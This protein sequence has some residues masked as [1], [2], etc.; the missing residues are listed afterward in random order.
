MYKDVSWAP[1]HMDKR[2]AVAAWSHLQHRKPTEE[3]IA[4][5]PKTMAILIAC[6]KGSGN[7][8]VLDFDTKHDE[9][10]TIVQRW[11]KS[12]SFSPRQ[13][14][15]PIIR[16]MSGGYHI[17]YRLPYTPEGN[18]K[19]TRNPNGDAVIETRGQGGYVIAPPHPSYRVVYNSLDN[20][21]TITKE[22]HEEMFRVAVSLDEMPDVKTF[23]N[24]G[25]E[26]SENAG[27]RPGD[28]YEQ[29]VSWMDILGPLG[30]HS[31]REGKNGI[32]YL[33][34]P[35][36]KFG[37]SGALLKSQ[38]GNQLFHCFT[39]SC[40]P[41]EPSTSYTKF[42]ARTLLEYDGD[43][44]KSASDLYYQNLKDSIVCN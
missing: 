33:T 38:Q 2:P 17:Y 1:A 21:P 7:L 20:I 12:L 6:G 39:S 35:G 9:T 36:K 30:W 42:G 11:A 28:Q 26:P 40:S 23:K 37:V 25:Q 16:T 18:Q 5:Y 29:Q 24:Y 32:I 19:L 41:F 13:L 15:L 3:E 43:F 8:E 34:R 27:S 22:Q 10:G 31:P 44:K 14:G 4:N